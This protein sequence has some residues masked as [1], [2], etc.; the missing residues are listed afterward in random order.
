MV[1]VKSSRGGTVR[2][3]ILGV[4][5]TLRLLRSKGKDVEQGADTGVL[6]AANFIKEEVQESIIGNRA[7]PKSVDTGLFG[8]NIIADKIRKAE[9]KIFTRRVKYP[10]TNTTTQEVATKLEFGTSTISPRM[11]FRNTEARNKKK[12]RNIIE[13]EI[14]RKI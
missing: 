2:V 12:I 14:K 13:K 1:L 4:N 6:L 3:E 11:H 10:G 8:D 5:E 9:F 7:E